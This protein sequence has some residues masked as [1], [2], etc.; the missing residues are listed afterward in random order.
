MKGEGVPCGELHEGVLHRL[1]D[2]QQ[3]A[4]VLA[5]RVIPVLDVV[6]QGKLNHLQQEREKGWK[7]RVTGLMREV[8]QITESR[9]SCNSEV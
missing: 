9:T 8:I 1:P 5:Q 2:L 7:E 4:L 6:P 3:E